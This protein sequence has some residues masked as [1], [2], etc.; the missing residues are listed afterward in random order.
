MESK[1]KLA[2]QRV[3]QEAVEVDSLPSLKAV[4]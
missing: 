1:V 4:F 2:K 3:A